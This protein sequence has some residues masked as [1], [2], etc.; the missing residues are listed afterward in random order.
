M[1]ER[2][3]DRER[4]EMFLMQVFLATRPFLF[5][6][7]LILAIYAI[8][9]FFAYPVVGVISLGLAVFLFLMVISDQVALLLARLGS[10]MIT[11]RS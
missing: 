1:P 6:G 7:G 4:W 9:A 5:I 10:W 3:T 11:F 2:H 8:S